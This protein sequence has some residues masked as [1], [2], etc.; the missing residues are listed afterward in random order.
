[1]NAAQTGEAT[2]GSETEFGVGVVECGVEGTEPPSS[3]S[4]SLPDRAVLLMWPFVSPQ[5]KLESDIYM[6]SP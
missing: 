4:Q 3:S 1:M 5:K 2:H 6:K